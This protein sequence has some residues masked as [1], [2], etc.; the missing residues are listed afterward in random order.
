MEKTMEKKIYVSNEALE[1]IKELMKAKKTYEIDD[2]DFIWL[3]Y[4]ISKHAHRWKGV[5]V[6]Y[7]DE[8]RIK[9]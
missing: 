1:V 9:I 2:D 7:A 4:R 3:L 5:P 6:Q 8:V